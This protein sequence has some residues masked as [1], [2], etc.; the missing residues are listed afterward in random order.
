VPAVPSSEAQRSAAGASSR[1]G[2]QRI[3][4]I[5][6]ALPDGKKLTPQR[7]AAAPSGPPPGRFMPLYGQGKGFYVR[8]FDWQTWYDEWQQVE[9]P[10]AVEITIVLQSRGPQARPYRFATLVTAD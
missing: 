8:S 2:P 1:E 4:Y 9:V 10:R 6:T 7:A 5:L 3:R